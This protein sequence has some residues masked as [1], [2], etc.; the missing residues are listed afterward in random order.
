MLQEYKKCNRCNNEYPATKEYFFGDKSKKDGLTTLCK[1]CKTTREVIYL[2]S[3]IGKV[4][5]SDDTC[6]V[7]IY[8]ITN[9]LNGMIYVGSTVNL[10]RRK[11]EH[12]KELRHNKHHSLHLQNSYNKYGEAIFVFT[13]LELV[14]DLDILTDREQYWI[15][16]Y[17]SSDKNL[18]Y[19]IRKKAESNVGLTASQSTR[20][21]LSN[22]NKGHKVSEETRIKLSIANKGKK[23][24]VSQ[25]TRLKLSIANKGKKKTQ[26]TKDKMSK[27]KI[28]YFKNNPI[29]QEGRLQ[30]SER[31][32]GKNNPKFGKRPSDETILKYSHPVLQYDMNNNLI[33]SYISTSETHKYGFTPSSVIDCCNGK[34]KKYKGYRWEYKDNQKPSLLNEEGS[35]TIENII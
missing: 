11:N 29:S 26:E 32:M 9:T 20:E 16:F 12:L 18:G 6:K 1:T 28:E 22:V 5:D 10:Y 7:G 34:T 30:R 21:R 27:A 8:K 17:K 35:T 31:M 24:I 2:E 13:I 15:D 3:D 14:F 33:R 25:E 4:I 19:N 23:R